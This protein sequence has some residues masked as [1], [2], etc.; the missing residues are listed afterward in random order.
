MNTFYLLLG[1][2]A[3]GFTVG[4][5]YGRKLEQKAIGAIANQLHAMGGEARSTAN[6][7]VA[8]LPYLKNFL[9]PITT[10]AGK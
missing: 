8:H 7:L 1:A 4:T 9:P 2:L 6:K 5:I 10:Q 3:G